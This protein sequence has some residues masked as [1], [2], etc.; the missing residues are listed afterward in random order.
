MPWGTKIWCLQ[1]F[2]VK[3]NL[4]KFLFLVVYNFGKFFLKSSFRIKN[5]ILKVIDYDFSIQD[6]VQGCP[7]QSLTF[8]RIEGSWK[9]VSNTLDLGGKIA[10]EICLKKLF[11]RFFEAINWLGLYMLCPSTSNFFHDQ[12]FRF[13]TW[14]ENWKTS[15]HFCSFNIFII[16][17]HILSFH[18][19]YCCIVFSYVISNMSSLNL[20]DCISKQIHYS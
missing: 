20:Y 9:W 10:L 19:W 4:F 15:T 18:K 3:Q 1:N 16:K 5:L 17:Y 14:K 7:L 8:Q 2:G 12:L 13:D 6:F 11:N